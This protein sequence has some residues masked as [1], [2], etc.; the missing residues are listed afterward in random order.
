MARGWSLGAVLFCALAPLCLAQ[1]AAGATV[2][3]VVG[4]DEAILSYQAD[5]GERNGLSIRNDLA[6]VRISVTVGD[7]VAVTPGPGCE[8]PPGGGPGPVICSLPEGLPLHIRARLG[9]G[10]DWAD[11]SNVFDATATVAGG[12]GN[13]S[14]TGPGNQNFGVPGWLSN[15]AK[16]PQARPA[17][18]QQAAQTRAAFFGGAG[19]DTIFG[20]AGPDRIIAGPGADYVVGW[21]GDD[22]VDARDDATDHIECDQGRDRLVLDRFDF[23]W[24][25]CGPVRRSGPSFVLPIHVLWDNLDIGGTSVLLGCPAD[26]PTA[27][28][29]TVSLSIPGGRRLSR[30]RFRIRP[31]RFGGPE[32]LFAE[33]T[34][35]RLARRGARIELQA[36]DS[37]GK[38][39]TVSRLIDVSYEELYPA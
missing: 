22:R 18:L 34:N 13:D 38:L 19:A 7:R 20:S 5:A 39:R 36:R 23:P 14:L 2:S 11:L 3:V 6:P 8:A 32:Y 35:E 10:D 15:K 30:S 28:R 16:R 37:R 24:S 27:C 4:T 29:G 12:P 31:G 26:S 17:R 33:E 9:D 25:H 1:A 21:R